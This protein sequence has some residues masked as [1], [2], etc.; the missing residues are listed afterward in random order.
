ML[1][2]SI[3]ATLRNFS[4]LVLLCALMLA[5]LHLVYGFLNRDALGVREMWSSI[6]EFPD[7][8][9]VRGVGRVQLDRE[10]TA[11]WGLI[12]GILV[13]VVP[14]LVRPTRRV[15]EADAGGEVPTVTG[16]LRGSRVPEASRPDASLVVGG[17]VIALLVGLVAEAA[18]ATLVPMLPDTTEWVGVA[19]GQ[20]LARSLG[21]PFLVTALALRAPTRAPRSLDLY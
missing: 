20:T 4:T 14:A 6:E 21:I 2:R 13:V 10:R 19:A 18:V 15:L 3:D 11:R 17:A 1:G 5:P 16:A 12:F 7:A 9:Q 8:R